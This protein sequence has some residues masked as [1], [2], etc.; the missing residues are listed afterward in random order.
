MCVPQPDR[1]V[2]PLG[3]AKL[4]NENHIS[5]FLQSGTDLLSRSYFTTVIL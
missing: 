1:S 2:V 4:W 5:V 3:H